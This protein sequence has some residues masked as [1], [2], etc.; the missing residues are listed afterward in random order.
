MSPVTQY[1]YDGVRW[2]SETAG[3]S[4]TSAADLPAYPPNHGALGSYKPSATTTGV[5]AGTALTRYPAVGSADIIVTTPGTVLDS[6]DIHGSVI[7]QAADVTI[8]RCIVRA[9]L[10]T[11]NTACVMAVDSRC[12]RLVVQDC[13]LMPEFPS[14]WINGING[15]D[16]TLLRCDI[17]KC[18]DGAGLFKT[19]APGT[20]LAVVIQGN[21]IHDLSWFSPDPN[22]LSDNQTHN[23]GIQ[24]QGGLGAVIQGNNIQSFRM[25]TTTVALSCVLL[26]D[27]VGKTGNHIIESNW[28]GGGYVPINALD[29][30]CGGSNYG[31]FWKNKFD[32][33]S[34]QRLTVRRLSTL[35]W[36]FGIGTANQNTYSDT[37]APITVR[38]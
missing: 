36:D 7:V 31:R 2:Q 8:K 32:G 13:K 6:L 5:P 19:S 15:H 18:V 14:V 9:K 1:I 35:I 17:S 10:V 27:N 23:D 34:F 38:T 33:N 4:I 24:I 30:S 37:G 16:F 25:G 26:N 3:A 11:T 28:F 12:L 20:N 21:Y 29:T 22:H